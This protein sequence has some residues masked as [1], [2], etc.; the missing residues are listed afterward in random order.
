MDFSFTVGG[1]GGYGDGWGSP[2]G[3]SASLIPADD[4]TAKR[5]G[6]GGGWSSSGLYG[7]STYGSIG[8]GMGTAY[9]GGSWSPEPEENR[10]LL[11][12]YYVN[13]T[14]FTQTLDGVSLIGDDWGNG[15]KIGGDASA[16]AKAAAAAKAK[17]KTKTNEKDKQPA[18]AGSNSAV[19][20]TKPTEAS[21]GKAVGKTAAASGTKASDEAKVETYTVKRGDSL[22]KIASAHGTT[23]QELY[24]LNKAAIG[25]NPSLIHAGLKLKLP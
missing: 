22:S 17:A 14:D 6:G 4:A 8:A 2:F 23:W 3:G 25:S 13:R 20:T 5:V 19:P 1:G 11:N 21:N 24:R 16:T 18:P 10:S 15:Y 9:V 12:G 7:Q